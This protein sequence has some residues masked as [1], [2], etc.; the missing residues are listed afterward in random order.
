MVGLLGGSDPLPTR[1]QTLGP[2]L[3]KEEYSPSGRQHSHRI[4]NLHDSNHPSVDFVSVSVWWWWWCKCCAYVVLA[5]LNKNH[6]I[7]HGLLFHN[8]V[9]TF[10]Y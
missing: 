3:I 10:L 7:F 6:E 2:Y 5:V 4:L 8:I 1:D 9:I